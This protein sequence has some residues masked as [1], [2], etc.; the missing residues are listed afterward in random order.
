MK[1]RNWEKEEQREHV[2]KQNYGNQ[3]AKKVIIKS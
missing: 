1:V 2:Y 3:N